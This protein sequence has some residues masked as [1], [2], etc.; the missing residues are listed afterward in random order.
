MSIKGLLVSGAVH[1]RATICAQTN[2]S[3]GM[4]VHL[5]FQ[6]YHTMRVSDPY[7]SV[8]YFPSANLMGI[9]KKILCMVS[10]IILP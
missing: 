1:I 7:I 3:V 4:Y 9:E 8:S 5:D 10:L 6:K 2:K